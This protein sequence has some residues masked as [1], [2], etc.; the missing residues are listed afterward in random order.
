MWFLIRRAILACQS[1]IDFLLHYHWR[2]HSRN[3]DSATKSS[4]FSTSY[5]GNEVGQ[6]SQIVFPLGGSFYGI[7]FPWIDVKP[8]TFGNV[9]YRDL[10][11]ISCPSLTFWWLNSHNLVILCSWRDVAGTWYISLGPRTI[12]IYITGSKHAVGLA[13]HFKKHSETDYCRNECSLISH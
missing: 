2:H 3:W 10:A 8:M 9:V 1:Q 7:Q 13:H 12:L 5:P 4:Q 6:L 11:K